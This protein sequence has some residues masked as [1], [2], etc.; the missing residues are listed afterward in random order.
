MLHELR[1]QHALAAGVT[2]SASTAKSSSDA[3]DHLRA[4]LARLQTGRPRPAYVGIALDVLAEPTDEKPERFAP[5][6]HLALPV[7]ETIEEAAR[8]LNGAE[9][10]LIPARLHSWRSGRRPALRRRS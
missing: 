2:G 10:P 5:A 6:A 3:R 4:A 8:L 9:R 7:P 1:D